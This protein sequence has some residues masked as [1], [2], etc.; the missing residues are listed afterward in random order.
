MLSLYFIPDINY[1]FLFSIYSFISCIHRHESPII[2][3]VN[4]DKTLKY[5]L[6]DTHY[7]NRFETGTSGGSIDLTARSSW[8]DRIFN[9]HY[10]PASPFDRVKYGVLNIVGDG[11][12]VK[13]C[14]G[15]GDSFLQLKKVRLRTTFASADTSLVS[16]K[17][18]SCEY[19][20][21]I[22]NVYS[23]SELKSIIDVSTRRKAW[24]SSNVITNYKEV[25]IHGP[26]SLSENVECI[27]VNERHRS[28]VNM[29]KDLDT[30]IKNN[31]CNLI[32]MD[33]VSD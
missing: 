12:G 13:S 17:L 21:N 14:Y 10:N 32:W 19:Y 11:K 33:Q 24:L 3:H 30:F 4:L 8:E 28:N 20:A 16:V 23:D 5:L 15:Y 1:I 22:L 6:S 25:Q 29:I 18:A 9:G 31:N 27:V 26:V 7:R 2:I